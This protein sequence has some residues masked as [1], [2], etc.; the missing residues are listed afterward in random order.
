MKR[1]VS[2]SDRVIIPALVDGHGK[3]R[4]GTVIG[5]Y[6]FLGRDQVIVRYDSPDP[7][8]RMEKAFYEH[9]IKKII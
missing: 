1:K 6:P 3:K 2:I 4:S 7:N 9:Q 8:G 5:I